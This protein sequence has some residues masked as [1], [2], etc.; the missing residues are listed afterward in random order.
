MSVHISE[1]GTTGLQAW[2]QEADCLASFYERRRDAEDVIAHRY[3][4]GAALRFVQLCD[5]RPA[6]QRQIN[7]ARFA[8]QE[9]HAL[10]RQWAVEIKQAYL[11]RKPCPIVPTDRS[12]YALEL[13]HAIAFGEES[14]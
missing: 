6:C 10:A 7:A 3:G 13:A 9:V 1:M 2:V 12:R 5:E 4:A 11:E 14:K 8:H